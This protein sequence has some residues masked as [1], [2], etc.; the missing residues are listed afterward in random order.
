MLGAEAQHDSEVGKVDPFT[1]LR[2]VERLIVGVRGWCVIQITLACP[3]MLNLSLSDTLGA[4]HTTWSREFNKVASCRASGV[5]LRLTVIHFLVTILIEST[6]VVIK[7]I[8]KI[9]LLCR[10]DL[11]L[12]FLTLWQDLEVVEAAT[13]DIHVDQAVPDTGRNDQVELV[14][15]CFLSRCRG[16]NPTSLGLL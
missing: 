16:Q 11:D 14:F 2:S 10:I 1:W 4:Y 8:V 6:L 15:H 12:S 9:F 5:G 3:V 7:S 13:A